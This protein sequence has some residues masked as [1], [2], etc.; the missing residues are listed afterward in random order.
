MSQRDM[1]GPWS[2]LLEGAYEIHERIGKARRSGWRQLRVWAHG[3]ARVLAAGKS[4]DALW[5]HLAAGLAAHAD[6][7]GVEAGDPAETGALDPIGGPS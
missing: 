1:W 5:V 4:P 6:L 7:R 3:A 2:V